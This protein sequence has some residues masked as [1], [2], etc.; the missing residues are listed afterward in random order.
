VALTVAEG[1]AAAG[2]APALGACVGCS[3]P[4]QPGRL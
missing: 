4:A 3:V 1:E 2:W